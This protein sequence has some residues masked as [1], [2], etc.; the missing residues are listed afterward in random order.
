VEL[1]TG[2]PHCQ[3]AHDALVGILAKTSPFLPPG[4]PLGNR[5]QGNIGE[6]MA[7]HLARTGV[8]QHHFAFA[9]NAFNPLQDI[10]QPGLD[11]TYL[12]FDQTDP[13]LDLMYVQEVKAT[14]Q[15]DLAYADK[16]TTD[17]SKLFGEDGFLTLNTR[18]QGLSMQMELAQSRPDLAERLINLSET[19]AQNCLQV[20]LVPTL[21]HERIGTAPVPKLVAVKSAITAF[22]WD[23]NHIAPWSIAMEDLLARLSRIAQG[24]A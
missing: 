12:Y 16:L 3:A 20:R 15:L 7:Y 13:R 11:V 6:F 24:L 8:L 21:I 17:Y 5:R 9:M 4:V 14:G 18:I 23:P 19:R 2:N 1:W 22:G 10:S